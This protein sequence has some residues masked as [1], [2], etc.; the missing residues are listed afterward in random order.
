MQW[1]K[2]NVRTL[3]WFGLLVLAGFGAFVSVKTTQ[4]ELCRKIEKKADKEP[5]VRELDL[6][7][8]TLLSIESKLDNHIQQDK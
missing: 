7:H 8:S 2:N 1:I 4:A 6:I 5:I 3:V